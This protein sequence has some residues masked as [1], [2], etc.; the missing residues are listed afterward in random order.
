L[1]G[2]A[3]PEAEG[4]GGLRTTLL[5]P[6]SS[7]KFRA[8]APSTGVI[9]SVQN[10]LFCDPIHRYGNRRAE[11]EI[12]CCPSTRG[13]K[14]RMLRVDRTSGRF[15]CRGTADKSSEEGATTYVI[16]GTKAVD[17]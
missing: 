8:A 11:E 9:L 3:F 16:N 13:G 10:S 15:E 17:H 1:T 14:D 4:R 2:V 6:S 12:F 5:T 7:K